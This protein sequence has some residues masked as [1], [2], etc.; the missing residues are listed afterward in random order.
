MAWK[1]MSFDKTE[2]RTVVPH[3]KETIK[4]PTPQMWSGPKHSAS[5]PSPLYLWHM[6]ESALRA[7]GEFNE[8]DFAEIKAALRGTINKWSKRVNKEIKFFKDFVEHVELENKS[9]I[10]AAWHEIKSMNG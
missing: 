1:D 4:P 3:Y 2:E 8:I 5:L 9:L 10:I 6:R 7:K